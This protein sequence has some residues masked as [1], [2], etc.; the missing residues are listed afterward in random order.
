MPRGEA[1]CKQPCSRPP[2]KKKGEAIVEWSKSGLS[3]PASAPKPM[4]AQL[5]LFALFPRSPARVGIVPDWSQCSRTEHSWRCLLLRGIRPTPLLT[6][7]GHRKQ[8]Q[9]SPSPSPAPRPA[10]PPGWQ[11]QDNLSGPYSLSSLLAPGLA[12]R[13]GT[14]RLRSCSP[15]VVQLLRPNIK[16]RGRHMHWEPY[17]RQRKKR[18][19]KRKTRLARN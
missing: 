9:P 15:L 17:S 14:Q 8:G 13:R 19:R 6:R 3:P 10:H 16:P 18:R 4:L 2:G 7:P 5:S 11:A 1:E 12:L